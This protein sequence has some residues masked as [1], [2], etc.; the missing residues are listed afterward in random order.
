MSTVLFPYDT[1][2]DADPALTISGLR[3]NGAARPHLVKRDDATVPLYDDHAPW[4]RAELDLELTCD[5]D[6]VR[7]FEV[8]HGPVS[9]VVVANCLPTNTRQPLRLARSELDPGRW[10]GTLELDRENYRDRVTLVTT[11]TAGVDGVPHRPV[12]AAPGWTVYADEPESL[13]LKGTLRVRWLNFKNPDAPLPARDFPRSTHIVAFTGGVP[14]LWLNSGFEGLEPLLRDRKDRRGADRGLH[15]FQR[16]GIARGV[17]LALIADALS[18]VRNDPAADDTSESDWPESQWQTEVL[19]LILPEVAPGKTER[20][21]LALAAVEWR[22]HPGAAEFFARAEAV[23]GDI[24][25]AN[26]SLRR[27][28]QTYRVEETA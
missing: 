19:K 1:L 13:R 7:P 8:R 5:P 2:A 21:L 10:S 18:A 25:K 26:E 16:T 17:W 22:E 27:F 23:V 6:R 24:V 11:M 12:A 20:E 3:L 4:R 15:D 28:V 9:V 14:E